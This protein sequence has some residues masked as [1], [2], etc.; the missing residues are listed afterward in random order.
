M[1]DTPDNAL[2]T[3][4]ELRASPWSSAIAGSRD[5]TC[6][7]Y[8]SALFRAA[9]LANEAG[10]IGEYRALRF[11]G[12]VTSMRLRLDQPASPFV[13]CFRSGTSRSAALEDFD[14]SQLALLDDFVPTVTDPELSARLCDVLWLGRRDHVRAEAAI[15]AYLASAAALE[16]PMSW[17]ECVAKLERASQIAGALRRPELL[18][19]VIV[20]IEGV[21]RRHP[22]TDPRYLSAKL[23]ELL[24]KLRKGDPAACIAIAETAASASQGNGDLHRAATYLEIK[25]S[26]QRRA[27]DAAGANETTRRIGENWARMAERIASGDAPAFGQAVMH[28]QRALEALRRAGG[29]GDRRREV[30]AALLRYQQG[31]LGELKRFEVT[32]DVTALVKRAEELVSGKEPADALVALALSYEPRPV[33]ELRKVVEEQAREHPMS[34]L[35]SSV[36]LTNQGRVAAQRGSF[37]GGTLEESEAALQ[38]EMCRHLTTHQ[39]LLGQ[40]L[41]EPARRRIIFEHEIREGALTGMLARSPFVPE[42]RE[43][44]YAKGLWAGLQGDFTTATHLLIPQMEHSVRVLLSERTGALTSNLKSDGAQDEH[45][46]N[47]TLRT[48]E[49]NALV[50]EDIAFDL[51]ALLIERFGSNLRNRF[52]HG[53]MHQSEFMA[54][55]GVYLWWVCLYLCLAPLVLPV[56]SEGDDA[57]DGSPEA[58]QPD[59]A[60]SS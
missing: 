24:F 27:G 34:F 17:S 18:D 5:K 11:L 60:P 46:L 35:F 53:L 45:D 37:L 57:T 3:S 42:G 22:G 59:P 32:R 9:D 2:P 14:A 26:W 50:G 33:A 21:L 43:A 12:H 41:V 55:D 16:D 7:H 31:A 52:A 15:H 10:K 58:V 30:H 36:V 6:V 40:T 56:P 38:A 8:S 48:P 19:S 47:T 25:A 13:P 23:L 44:L 39:Q 29:A 4:D 1:T 28:A 51:R 54:Y 20:A 49:I